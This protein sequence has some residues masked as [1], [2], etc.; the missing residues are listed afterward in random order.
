MVDFVLPETLDLRPDSERSASESGR[1]PHLLRDRVEETV[2]QSGIERHAQFAIV[3][4]AKGNEA[5]RLKTRALKL[6]HRAQHFGHAADGAG[7]GVEND[8]DEIPGGKLVLQL[9]QASGDGNRL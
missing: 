8:F 5:E 6:A 7:S 9:Q 1:R 4:I 3:F 2:V